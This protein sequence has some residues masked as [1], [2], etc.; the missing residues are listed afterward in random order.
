QIIKTEASKL[1]EVHQTN[2]LDIVGA[3]AQEEYMLL[4]GR[5]HLYLRDAQNAEKQFYEASLIKIIQDRRQRLENYIF[6]HYKQSFQTIKNFYLKN[7]DGILQQ[8]PILQKADSDLIA[9]IELIKL[10]LIKLTNEINTVFNS[11]H[12]F[13][14]LDDHIKKYNTTLYS[15]FVNYFFSIIKDKVEP[16]LFRKGNSQIEILLLDTDGFLAS[17]N[18]LNAV[19]EDKT[20]QFNATHVSPAPNSIL[21]TVQLHNS[22]NHL[23]FL[24]DYIDN[25]T[26]SSKDLMEKVNNVS[27]KFSYTEKLLRLC[28]QVENLI[29]KFNL[30][31]ES[32]FIFNGKLWFEEPNKSLLLADL[33]R[34]NCYNIF[35]NLRDEFT[36][37]KQYNN[38]VWIKNFILIES[39]LQT[40]T[41]SVLL[42]AAVLPLDTYFQLSKLLQE[43]FKETE[44]DTGKALDF[45][46]HH[47]LS[48]GEQLLQNLQTKFEQ[49]DI[50]FENPVHAL[51]RVHYEPIAISTTSGKQKK[52]FGSGFYQ[53]QGTKYYLKHVTNA[54]YVADD[55]VEVLV[56]NLSSYF[57]QGHLFAQCHLVKV[58][59]N[60]VF[61]ASRCEKDFT[62]LVNTDERLISR[63]TK[64]EVTNLMTALTE[65]KRK[66]LINILAFALLW[67]DYDCNPS[68]IGIEPVQKI[69]HGWA[70]E[71]I[72]REQPMIIE[73]E[74]DFLR[75]LDRFAPTNTFRDYKAFLRTSSFFDSVK[76]LSN[77]FNLQE[78]RDLVNN[79]LSRVEHIYHKS[80]API[81][82]DKRLK[83]AECSFPGIQGFY[84]K[85]EIRYSICERVGLESNTDDLNYLANKITEA[86]FIRLQVLKLYCIRNREN[87]EKVN[88]SSIQDIRDILLETQEKIRGISLV[89]YFPELRAML[90]DLYDAF[91]QNAFQDKTMLT[92]VKQCALLA[93]I[94]I[95]DKNYDVEPS[96]AAVNNHFLTDYAL[97]KVKRSKEGGLPGSST[98]KQKFNAN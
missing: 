22:L 15:K 56:S 2:L 80:K 32:S 89:A 1:N 10:Q 66:Q 43:K 90:L 64:E 93:S 18:T 45:Y 25:V 59:N 51:R 31:I 78:I 3:K 67:G 47:M 75:Y 30:P 4:K 41:I 96:Y 58:D 98:K 17:F 28:M 27:L 53:N 73:E 70:F 69:D 87:Q 82:L 21:D 48:Q 68:N 29:K 95:E 7:I 11:N 40:I 65:D 20:I 46:A 5:L 57:Q 12:Y 85:K 33:T 97:K 13:T 6:S 60:E 9:Y 76:E 52:A 81:S 50:L 74:L 23:I 92:M 88:L 19:I 14:F 72:C 54:N 34:D 86:L 8:E 16:L 39:I 55:I 42:D 61:L 44:L 83:K 37:K 49:E 24:K 63:L 84:T 91:S 62:P 36:T 77:R 79:T 94:D 71:N 38:I 26:I 35:K